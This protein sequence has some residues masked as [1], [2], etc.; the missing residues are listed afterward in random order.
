MAI[1]IGLD[2]LRVGYGE[3]PG[4]T[5]QLAPVSDLAACLGVERRAVEDD[6][7]GLAG[8]HR[9]HRSALLIQRDHF[10][11]VYRERFITPE[12]GLVPLVLDRRA[13]LE[14]GCG[15]RALALALHRRLEPGVIH[16]D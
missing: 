11:I 4:G 16:P 10:R 6:Y 14:L 5:A 1:D 9:S 7:R 13:E 15:A 8:G 3:R 2:F 12:F